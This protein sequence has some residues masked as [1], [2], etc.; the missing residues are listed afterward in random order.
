MPGTWSNFMTRASRRRY[1]QKLIQPDWRHVMQL[2]QINCPGC[3]GPIIISLGGFPLFSG[4]RNKKFQVV[5]PLCEHG[6]SI[7]FISEHDTESKVMET[8]PNSRELYA[9]ES[10]TPAT[11]GGGLGAS[12]GQSPSPNDQRSKALNPNNPTHQSAANNRSNQM[13]PNNPAYRSPR[14]GRR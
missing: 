4:P 5:C 2:Q 11:G 9:D 14:G 3:T 7:G 10:D 12:S 13:N 1:S 8:A 6:F